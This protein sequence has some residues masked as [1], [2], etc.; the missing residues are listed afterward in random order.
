MPSSRHSWLSMSHLHAFIFFST[1]KKQSLKGSSVFSNTMHK[2][3]PEQKVRMAQLPVSKL[4]L[5]SVVKQHES[6]PLLGFPDHFLA[7]LHKTAELQSLCHCPITSAATTQMWKHYS[8]ILYS[9]HIFWMHLTANFYSPLSPW[10]RISW[11]SP[12]IT[13]ASFLT[14]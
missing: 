3:L 13:D 6:L 10:K 11:E 9:F 8:K 7:V 2:I 5:H 1:L 4:A 14:P 12:T